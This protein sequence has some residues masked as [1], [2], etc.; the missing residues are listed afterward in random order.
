MFRFQTRYSGNCRQGK[1]FL[2]KRLKLC[3]WIV[4][5]S[6]GHQV[7]MQKTANSKSTVFL[8][9]GQAICNCFFNPFSPTSS[10]PS[11]NPIYH[12]LKYSFPFWF[13]KECLKTSLL[14]SVSKVHLLQER[15]RLVGCTAGGEDGA[16]EED[17]KTSSLSILCFQLASVFPSTY[18]YVFR[19]NKSCLLGSIVMSVESFPILETPIRSYISHRVA[20]NSSPFFG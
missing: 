18:I 15:E 12:Q 11:L 5:L 20:F 16:L 10:S 4:V 2:K 8:V 19:A 14:A 7:K 6:A 17:G 3:Q 9:N 13:T 1:I